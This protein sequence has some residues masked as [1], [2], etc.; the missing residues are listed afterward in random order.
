MLFTFLL[1]IINKYNIRLTDKWFISSKVLDMKINTRRRNLNI[2]VV[3]VKPNHTRS[4][5]GLIT[6]EQVRSSR[7]HA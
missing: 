2:N 4:R 1:I 6:W 7:F 5:L 3:D